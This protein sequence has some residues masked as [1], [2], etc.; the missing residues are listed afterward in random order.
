MPV[1]ELDF[2]DELLNQLRAVIPSEEIDQFTLCAV[3]EWVAWLE[4]S[5]RPISISELETNRIFT[6]YTRVLT[7][8]LP[9]VNHLGKLLHFPMGRSRYIIQNLA[10]RYG[11]MLL[12]RQIQAIIQ[13][14]RQSESADQVNYM[15]RIHHTCKFI[16]DQTI[17]DLRV[18]E[19]LRSNISGTVTPDGVLY[20]LG[21]SQRDELIRTYDSM[22]KRQ[23]GG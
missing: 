12:Q 9:S 21:S 16:M 11:K 6:L 13:A 7:T 2:P 19:R 14:L 23:A 22:R 18:D 3:E 20:R 1:I 15:V 4:G 5:L 17:H 8:E 10:Y